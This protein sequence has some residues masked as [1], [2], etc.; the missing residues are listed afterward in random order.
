MLSTSVKNSRNLCVGDFELKVLHNAFP[1]VLGRL[2]SE[3][4]HETSARQGK[5]I[6]DAYINAAN[7]AGPSNNLR[8]VRPVTRVY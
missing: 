4:E 2:R 8:T 1:A 5:R 7:E 3:R 6:Y